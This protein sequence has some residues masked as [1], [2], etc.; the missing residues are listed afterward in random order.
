MTGVPEE[1]I[2]S[3]H[4]TMRIIECEGCKER[5]NLEW[6]KEEVRKNIR[7]ISGE[8]KTAPEVSKEIP[9]QKCNM[10]LLKP[11]TVLFG[12]MLPK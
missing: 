8:D 12:G 5:A 7:D 10:P 4:G 2:I 3:V 6:F 11:A 1:D 9:C